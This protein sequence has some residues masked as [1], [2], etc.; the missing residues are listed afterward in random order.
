MENN[1]RFYGPH[2]PKLPIVKQPNSGNTNTLTFY[3]ERQ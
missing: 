2:S 1:N 3:P